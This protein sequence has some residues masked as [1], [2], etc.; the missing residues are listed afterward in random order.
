MLPEGTYRAR[1]IEAVSHVNHKG[2][3][4]VQVEFEIIDGEHAGVRLEDIWYLSGK[5]GSYTLEKLRT[6]G[7]D[8]A[9]DDATELS[10]FGTV[11]CDIVVQH[12][13]TPKGKTVARIQYVNEPGSMARRKVERLSP[14]EAKAFAARWRATI[15]ALPPL[16]RKRAKAKDAEDVPF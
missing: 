8:L 10:D 6:A 11:E 14:S 5:G 1:G 7:C 13:V 12:D 2:T 9:D 16:K 3:D 15:K 4:A